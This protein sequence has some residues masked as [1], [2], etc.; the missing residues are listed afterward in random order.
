LRSRLPLG[1]LVI[2]T[3]LVIAYA[4]IALMAFALCATVAVLKLRRRRERYLLRYP[5]QRL[6]AFWARRRK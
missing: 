6:P 4:L 1:I 5:H 2:E 3:R